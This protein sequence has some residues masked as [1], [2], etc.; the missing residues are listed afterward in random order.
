[1]NLLI[2]FNNMTEEKLTPN[3]FYLLYCIHY[4][5]APPNINV[6]QELRLLIQD[7]WLTQNDKLYLLEPKSMSLIS[8]MESYFA[9]QL[10]KSDNSIMGDDF[11]VNAEKYNTLFPRMKLGSNKPARA[12][13]KEIITSF[14]WFFTEHD[15]TWDVILDATEL[16]LEAEE[17]KGYKYTRTSKYFIRK[18]ESDKSWSSDLAAYCDLV[19]NGEEFKEP[20]F[21]EK[22]F[23]K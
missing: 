22:V 9:V 17:A 7:A 10:K 21:T 12:P 13:I 6:H 20:I 16:Y 3:Q 4:S 5:I 8:K 1:M 14:R 23:G 18:Q 19:L 11:D 15:Y 2:L